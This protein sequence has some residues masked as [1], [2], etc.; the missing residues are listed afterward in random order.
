MITSVNNQIDKMIAEAEKLFQEIITTGD[1]VL[2]GFS[3]GYLLTLVFRS[4]DTYCKTYGSYW[5]WRS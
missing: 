3:C 4:P 5:M 1:H 2:Y